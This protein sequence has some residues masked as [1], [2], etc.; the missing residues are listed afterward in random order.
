MSTTLHSGPEPS[1]ADLMSLQSKVTNVT[2]RFQ[3]VI[4]DQNG[5]E[6]C[7]FRTRT[8]LQDSPEETSTRLF[9]DLLREWA[10]FHDD[11]QNKVARVYR[12]GRLPA[13]DLQTLDTVMATGAMILSGLNTAHGHSPED[14]QVGKAAIDLGCALLALKLLRDSYCRNVDD[15]ELEQMTCPAA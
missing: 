11:L 8:K 15:E 4:C 14:D 9:L 7:S 5:D 10:V 2:L 3:L 12:Y 1:V 6:L 13:R